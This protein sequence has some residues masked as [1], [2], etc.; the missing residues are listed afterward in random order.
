MTIHG[1]SKKKEKKK[2]SEN[3]TTK[4]LVMEMFDESLFS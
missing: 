1:N 4:N 2:R 3:E